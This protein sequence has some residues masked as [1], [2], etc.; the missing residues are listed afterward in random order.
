MNR[1]I[2]MRG[3]ATVTAPPD[4][5]LVSMSVSGRERSFPEAL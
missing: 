4:I 5:T 1:T 2:K 3:S